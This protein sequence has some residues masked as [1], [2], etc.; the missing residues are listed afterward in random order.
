MHTTAVNKDI[1]VTLTRANRETGR[2]RYASL[3]GGT[4]V[5]SE[6]SSVW[7]YGEVTAIV[8]TFVAVLIEARRMCHASLRTHV[9]Q[10][11]ESQTVSSRVPPNGGIVNYKVPG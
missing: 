4:L 5:E 3:L 6:F 11:Q 2:V 8:V 7:A 10:A 1:G 9:H